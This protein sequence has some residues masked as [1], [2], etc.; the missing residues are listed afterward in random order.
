MRIHYYKLYKNLFFISLNNVKSFTIIILNFITNMLFAK[1][2]YVNKIY[3]VILILINK[4]LKHITY[5]NIN[6][7]LNA[8]KF[9]CYYNIIKKFISN[10]KSLFTNYF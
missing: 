10:K 1:E 7:I 3:N 9:I 8:K 2:F 5:I 4:L 6:K